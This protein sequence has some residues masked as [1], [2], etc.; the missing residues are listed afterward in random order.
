PDP[1]SW[2]RHLP[3]LTFLSVGLGLGTSS[4]WFFLWLAIAGPHRSAFIGSEAAIVVVVGLLVVTDRR[5]KVV[6]TP[7]QESADR[8]WYLPAAAF[9]A[10]LLVAGLA[11][12]RYS[13]AAPHGAWDAW[14]DWNL[15][16]RFLYLGGTHWTDVFSPRG[17]MPHRDYP[18]LLS[19]TVAR[20]WT[21]VNRDSQGAP[22]AIAFVFTF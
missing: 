21:Y 18:L 17:T 9:V 12:T 5:R 11:F 16:A 20:C 6:L 19:A 1:G 8:L 13:A 14:G 10:A 3:L 2:R 15:R 7:R 4:L 22:M